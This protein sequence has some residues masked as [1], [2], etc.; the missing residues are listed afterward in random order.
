MRCQQ[1]CLHHGSIVGD[2]FRTHTYS[3]ATL[4]S[5]ALVH[6]DSGAVVEK[7]ATFTNIRSSALR[8]CQGGA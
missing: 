7:G 6:A 8:A 1:K 2:A 3:S 4:L 5:R